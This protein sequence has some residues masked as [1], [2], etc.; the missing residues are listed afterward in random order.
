MVGCCADGAAP[1]SYAPGCAP[2]GCAG[3]AWLQDVDSDVPGVMLRFTEE[4]KSAVV[5]SR[6]GMAGVAGYA[7]LQAS[8]WGF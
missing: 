1:V 6:P 3:F 2:R 7:W 5:G 4:E 8:W